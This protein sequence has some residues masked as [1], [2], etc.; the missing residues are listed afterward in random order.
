MFARKLA[1]SF[2]GKGEKEVSKLVAGPRVFI[3]DACV[4]EATRIMNDPNAQGP[5][6]D[7]P[8]TILRRLR[9]WIGPRH[10]KVA[11]VA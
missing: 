4:A 3:C 8:A 6:K 11:E 10:S 1:C 7:S 2:C 9:E 5:A